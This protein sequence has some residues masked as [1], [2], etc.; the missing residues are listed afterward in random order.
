MS[1]GATI[2]YGDVLKVTYTENTGYTLSSKG[3][4]SITVK[5]NV[6]SS[7]IYATATANSYTYNIVYKSVNGTALGT[8]S[9]TYKF[10]T[11]NTITPKEFAGYTTPSAKSVKWDSTNKKTIEFIYK[12]TQSKINTVIN[13]QYVEEPPMRFN[14]VID[15]YRYEDTNKGYNASD[16]IVLEIEWSTIMPAGYWY[17]NMS[18]NMDIHSDL[19]IDGGAEIMVVPKNTWSDGY[20]PSSSTYVHPDHYFVRIKADPT[21]TSVSFY[22]VLHQYRTDGTYYNTPYYVPFTISIPTY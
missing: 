18:L 3:S 7:T 14:A 21:A 12:P 17:N 6:T 19:E 5:G 1:N 9:V 2:Y 20:R 15:A 8:D 10:G 13:E 22:I 11:T 4:E 16:S